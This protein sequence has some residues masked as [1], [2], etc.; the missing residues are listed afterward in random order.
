[1]HRKAHARTIVTAALVATSAVVTSASPAHAA[2]ACSFDATSATMTIDLPAAGDVVPLFTTRTGDLSFDYRPCA[3]GAVPATVTNV[4]TI[5]VT[6]G[7]G[8]QEFT[9][10]LEM[11]V[12]GP[13]ATDE[14]GDGD[15]IEVDVDLGAGDA[16]RFI[17]YGSYDPEWFT[18]TGAGL[19]NLNA[20]EATDDVDVTLAGVEHLD[21]FSSRGDDVIDATG[22]T[23]RFYGN[24]GDG[25][26][27]VYGALGASLGFSKLDGLTGNDKLYGGPGADEIAGFYGDDLMVGNDGDDMFQSG[28]NDDDA[29]VI[30]GGNGVD[31]MS[32]LARSNA[33]RITL[34][35]S[36]NDGEIAGA[37][38]DNVFGDVEVLVGGKGNDVL[39]GNR[40]G[41]T[42]KGRDGND[43]LDGGAGR[44][45]LEG[46]T[47]ADTLEGG[48]GID[49]MYGGP[50]ND[51][52]V[53]DD[54][55]VD[56]ADG[57]TGT[58]TCSCDPDDR[59]R[60]LP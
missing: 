16:D 14:A 28:A 52:L 51:T 6:G 34:D 26:D 4:D 42:L 60:S 11:G 40:K 32:Y 24:A 31:T 58:D 27:T 10:Y 38:G 9:L 19:V 41:N 17:L 21:V 43:D 44:D 2:P 1:M 59:R 55:Q 7:D 45:R 36:A 23:G 56:L 15:E 3:D 18:V 33:V 39:G 25:A 8:T 48:V 57:G 20:A 46:E 37:E 35:G 12:L 22:Y 29:D 30:R 5:E 47:G 50:D 13:G 54:G 49:E 53:A